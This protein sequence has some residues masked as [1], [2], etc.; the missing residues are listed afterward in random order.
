LL[1]LGGC[2]PLLGE[3][4]IELRQA[5]FQGCDA[6]PQYLAFQVALG[7]LCLS[8]GQVA[9]ESGHFLV[10]GDLARRAIFQPCG[11]S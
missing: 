8:Q 5:L 2:L 1:R 11:L 9:P 10:R 3:A 6:S 4:I 7:G